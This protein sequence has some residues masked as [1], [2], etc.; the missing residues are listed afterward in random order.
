MAR[1]ALERGLQYVAITDHS[2]THGFGN[3]V[4]PDALK[5]QIELVRRLNDELDGI[6][7][8][9][10]TETNILPDGSPDYDD[11]LLAELDWVVGSVHTGFQVGRAEMTRRVIAAC[12][13]PS[14]DCIGHLTG[15]KLER[16]P[17]YEIDVD[18][19]FAAAARTGTMLEI[20][21]APDRRDLNDVHARQARAAGVTIVINTDAHG[22]NTQGISRWGVATARRAGLTAD[23]VANTK[24]W[25]DFA[26]LRKRAR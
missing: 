4:S 6:E 10:G 12:E 23:D 9:V 3:D 16:R 20:N 5:R 22:V 7:V 14:I 1:G 17:P 8:L 25:A 19:V 21:S 11:D 13:H 24:P 15:R 2:A 18:A 26:P